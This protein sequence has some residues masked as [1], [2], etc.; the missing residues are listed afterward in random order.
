MCFQFCFAFISLIMGLPGRF[1]ILYYLYSPPF[2]II[3]FNAR[4]RIDVLFFS[5][6]IE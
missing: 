2:L 3:L 6:E 1:L 4:V 5:V